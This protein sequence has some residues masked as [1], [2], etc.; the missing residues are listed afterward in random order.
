MEIDLTR[1][2]LV[3]LEKQRL[4]SR[5]LV[6]PATASFSLMA[7]STMRFMTTL[8]TARVMSRT[9]T[10]APR[11]KGS[12]RKPSVTL[13]RPTGILLLGG[14]VVPGRRRRVPASPDL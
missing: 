3:R 12:R 13:S 6:T 5:R 1:A 10:R 2:A 4:A 14:V 7:V 8:R 9:T 11:E